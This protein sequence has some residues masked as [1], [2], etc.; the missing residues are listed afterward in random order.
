MKNETLDQLEKSAGEL[1]ANLPVLFMDGKGD[2][3]LRE[4]SEDSEL[5]SAKPD[6]ILIWIHEARQIAFGLRDALAAEPRRKTPTPKK[7]NG[8]DAK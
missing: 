6:D 8:E 1:A 5:V 3:W 2:L 7:A 4:S